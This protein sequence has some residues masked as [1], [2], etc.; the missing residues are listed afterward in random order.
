MLKPIG[1]V[2]DRL[3]AGTRTAR[4]RD[5]QAADMPDN[6]ARREGPHG[7]TMTRPDSPSAF[8]EGCNDAVAGDEV[9]Q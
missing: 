2:V 9:A 4:H 1:V 7:G 3:A 5:H 8:V 6:G